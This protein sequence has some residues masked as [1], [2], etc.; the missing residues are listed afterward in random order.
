MG[1]SKIT[2]RGGVVAE[3][4]GP[5]TDTSGSPG[6]T[7]PILDFNGNLMADETLGIAY[8]GTVSHTDL[9]TSD[10]L[11]S[12]IGLT[13]GTSI[14]NQEVWYKY[15]WNNGI[16]FFRGPARIV[17]WNDIW[18]RGAVYGTGTPTSRKGFTPTNFNGPNLTGIDQ[19]REVIKN[20]VTYIVRL[21]E[22]TI[23]EPYTRFATTNVHGSEFNLI[24]GNLHVATNS[25]EYST[26]PTD[27]ISYVNWNTGNFNNDDFV[28]WKTLLNDEDFFRANERFVQEREETR[29]E[30][31]VY[32]SNPDLMEVAGARVTDATNWVPVLTVKALGFTYE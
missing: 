20:N 32:R 22:G 31:A 27:G 24:L 4:I 26:S 12:E 21:M 13:T 5:F 18:S 9:Y 11:A 29:P 1:E 19:D 15:Y 10:E 3:P 25:G 6:N 28:G 17:S 2:R 14:N 8:Y 23:Q 7:E 16:H 30:R